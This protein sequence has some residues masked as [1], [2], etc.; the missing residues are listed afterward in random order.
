[1]NWHPA[2]IECRL[3]EVMLE[4]DQHIMIMLHDLSIPDVFI[5]QFSDPSLRPFFMQA[6]EVTNGEYSACVAANACQ[7]LPFRADE[8][9]NDPNHPVVGANLYAAAAYCAWKKGRL[10]TRTEWLAAAIGSPYPHTRYIW[11]DA[12][13]NPPAQCANCATPYAYTAP[14]L[15][16]SEGESPYGVRNMFGNVAEWVLDEQDT[17]YLMGGSWNTSLRRLRIGADV[18]HL[19]GVLPLL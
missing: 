13:V 5:D 6:L 3:I 14:A 2:K 7:Q 4:A 10:P 11:G 8:R 16:F 18:L 17:G 12:E 9:F 19:R 15:S 1:M